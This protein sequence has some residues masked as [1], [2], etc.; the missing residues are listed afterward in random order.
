MRLAVVDGNHAPAEAALLE[1]IRERSGVEPLGVV[2]TLLYRP[3]LFGRPFSDALEAAMRGPS[4]WSP[5]E[6][7]LFAGFTSLLNHCPF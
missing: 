6:R 7:E 4:E 2:K 3:E 5:G 1:Q